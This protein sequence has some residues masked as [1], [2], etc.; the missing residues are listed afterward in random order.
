M[1]LK[2]TING[3]DK[4]VGIGTLAKTQL[5][6]SYGIRYDVWEG[7]TVSFSQSS[8]IKVDNQ[9]VTLT[10]PNNSFVFG[11]VYVDVTI[12]ATLPDDPTSIKWEHLAFK[13]I[14]KRIS[15]NGFDMVYNGTHQAIPKPPPGILDVV[16]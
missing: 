13:S 9:S 5:T 12:T 7:G 2:Y 6:D 8:Y 15:T 4:T 3:K 10:Y 16:P 11:G 14:D 1:T